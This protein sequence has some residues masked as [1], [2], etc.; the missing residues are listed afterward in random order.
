ME[1]NTANAIDGAPG[2][3]GYFRRALAALDMRGE[4]PNLISRVSAQSFN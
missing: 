3:H 1:Q 4:D 2:A